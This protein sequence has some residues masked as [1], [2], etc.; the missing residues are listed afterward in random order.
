MNT[1]VLVVYCTV[2]DENTGKS[3][4]AAIVAEKL[5]ACVNILP[6]VLSVYTW[7]EKIEQEQETLLMIK[8]TTSCYAALEAKLLAL[9][10][11]D[12]PEIIA[13]PVEKGAI[14]YLNWVSDSTL[15]SPSELATDK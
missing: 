9:H 7:Q 11:Y 10:P 3:I 8:T 14:S 4:A 6:T 5:A 13:V 12:T 2:P 15:S 1:Q